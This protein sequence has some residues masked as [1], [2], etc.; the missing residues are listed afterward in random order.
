MRPG[1][2]FL[3][4]IISLI[5][6]GNVW[7]GADSRVVLENEQGLPICCEKICVQHV[8]GSDMVIA[9]AGSASLH[10]ILKYRVR[11]PASRRGETDETYVCKRV[12]PQIQKALIDAGHID[13]DEGDVSHLP[14]N[15]EVLIARRGQC[16]IIETDFAVL[17]IK[18]GAFA[19]S[20]G[21]PIALGSLHTSRTWDN[22]LARIIEALEAA[23]NYSTM[24]APPFH[25]VKLDAQGA[26]NWVFPEAA[27][28]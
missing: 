6:N 22:P 8:S 27:D 25:L 5:E 24:V 18:S 19:L 26:A 4:C 13:S 28:A 11:Y 21:A 2:Q 7:V 15:G 10:T 14:R 20:S 16:F 9:S 12:L 3:T 23:A 17:S 1:G